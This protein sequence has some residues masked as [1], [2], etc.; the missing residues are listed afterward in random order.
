ML[1]T[2]EKPMKFAYA[3]VFGILPSAQLLLPNPFMPEAVR[4]A[5]FAEISSSMLLFGAVA[6]WVLGGRR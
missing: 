3:L 2:Q 4:L 6:G 5:H 1:N